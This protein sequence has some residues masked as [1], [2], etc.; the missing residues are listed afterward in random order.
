MEPSRVRGRDAEADGEGDDAAAEGAPPA[1]K[2]RRGDTGSPAASDP[3]ASAK[4]ARA[5][6]GKLGIGTW[7]WG[8]PHWGYGQPGA[9]YDD[10]SLR[11]AFRAALRAGV[12]FFDTSEL[13]GS[14]IAETLLG[15]C[16]RTAPERCFVATKWHPVINAST[17]AGAADESV[18][19]SMRRTVL[20]SRKRLGLRRLDLLQVHSAGG[21]AGDVEAYADG[22]AAMVREG[23][24]EQ[25]GVSNFDAAQ[26][27]RTAERLQDAHGLRLFSCQVEFSLLELRNESNGVLEECRRLGCI[28]LAYCP[29]GMGRLTGKYSAAREPPWH[30]DVALSSS[31]TAG[32]K[33]G[34]KGRVA[35][36]RYH[37]AL[38]WPFVDQM[39]EL[40]RDVSERCGRSVTQVA[41]NW[42]IARGT[43][44][45]PGAKT[46]EQAEENGAA[47]DWRLD[48]VDEERLSHLARRI[49]REA[50]KGCLKG[51]GKKGAKG[52]RKGGKPNA[53]R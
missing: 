33:G 6:V 53:W 23:H 36:E 46:M 28:V 39:L 24:V 32:E 45:I 13:Y 26:L 25:V 52:G 20:G 31:T 3:E 43:V 34:K 18:V 48:D 9:E 1:Q 49:A 5:L 14:N 19:D 21:A 50:A 12:R 44:P 38:P 4:A 10:D 7:A 15:E 11:A 29:L 8:D 16:L 2:L 47:A 30:S 41:L 17:H 51:G 27:R 37:A 40:L 35:T 42:C 22:L